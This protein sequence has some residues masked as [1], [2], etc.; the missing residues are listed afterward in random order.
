LAETESESYADED[1][2]RRKETLELV[3]AYYRIKDAQVRQ[4]IFELC[5]TMAH[6]NAE[7]S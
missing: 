2:M 5:R 7:E 1:P 6:T 3:R 4:R